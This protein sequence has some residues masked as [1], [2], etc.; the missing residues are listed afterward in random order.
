MIARLMLWHLHS[1]LP[2]LPVEHGRPLRCLCIFEAY[3]PECL[4]LQQWTGHLRPRS[5]L[6]IRHR[7]GSAP[8]L[9]E[10][11][12]R[13]PDEVI[14]FACASRMLGSDVSALG[15]RNSAR[16]VAA[17]TS[18]CRCGSAKVACHWPIRPAP[19]LKHEMK[20]HCTS[21]CE[22]SLRVSGRLSP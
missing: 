3:D 15:R 17:P 21:R 11:I 16:T 13:N 6:I 10:Q 9:V 18:Q 8:H 22:A 7:V 12:P 14:Y 4:W 1:T 2:A 19:T 20:S 5:R